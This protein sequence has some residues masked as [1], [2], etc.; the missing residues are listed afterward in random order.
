MNALACENGLA[1]MAR[2]THASLAHREQAVVKQHASEP[3]PD[4]IFYNGRLYVVN[5]HVFNLIVLLCSLACIVH[6]PWSPMRHLVPVLL[7]AARVSFRHLLTNFRSV[8]VVMVMVVMMVVMVMV[9]VWRV[10]RRYVSFS[11]KST[12]H[13]RLEEFAEEW[14][15]DVNAKAT[16]HNDSIVPQTESGLVFGKKE[17]VASTPTSPQRRSSKDPTSPAAAA[18]PP[19][20]DAKVSPAPPSTGRPRPPSAGSPSRA[21]AGSPSRRSRAPGTGDGGGGGGGA[22]AAGGMVPTPPPTS[23]PPGSGARGRRGGGRRVS[24]SAVPP[25]E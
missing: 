2:H 25:P 3:L 24:A 19:P 1:S 4:G 21:A 10:F 6:G 11:G 20:L 15:A 5:Q 14:L 18:R 17:R 23:G 8:L 9:M 7:Q 13:P 22:A 12:T 16:V